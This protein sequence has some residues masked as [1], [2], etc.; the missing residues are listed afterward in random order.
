M[1][2]E[3]NDDRLKEFCLKGKFIPAC[4]EQLGGLATPRPPAEIKGGT[5]LDVLW[6]KAGVY[7]VQGNDVTEKFH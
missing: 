3:T 4:P 5:G 2:H 6:G 7:T 1:K